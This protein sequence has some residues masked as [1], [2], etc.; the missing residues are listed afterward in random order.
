MESQLFLWNHRKYSNICAIGVLEVEERKVR[1]GRM[2]T[3]NIW[4]NDW[5][6]NKFREKYN[7]TDSKCSVSPKLKIKLPYG[8]SAQI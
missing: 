6:L 3:N 1:R 7:I 4:R 8:Q 2:E 5:K